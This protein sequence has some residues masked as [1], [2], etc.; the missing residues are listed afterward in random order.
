[1][2]IFRLAGPIGLFMIGSQVQAQSAC[3]RDCLADMLDSYMNA[4]IAGDPDAAPI[5]V[6]FRQTENAINVAPGAGVWQTVTGLGQVDRRYYDEVSGQAAYFGTVEEGDEEA[7][8]TVRLRVEDRELTEAEWYLARADDPGMRGA[9]PPGGPPA[10]L[11]NPE[12]LAMYPPPQRVVP[13]AQRV[14]RATLVRIG[15]SYFDA[16]T[17]HD[18]TVALHHEGCGRAENGSPAPGGSF[19]PPADGSEPPPVGS[20]RDC[21]AG[22]EGFDMQMVVAR[23][24]PVVDIE[25]QVVLTTGVFIRR[26]GSQTPRLVFSEWFVIDDA[27][28]R[29]VYTSMFY[30][31]ND[32][33]VPNW[34][35][36]TGNWPLPA[37][38]IPES[39]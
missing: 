1:M 31:P 30:P 24:T 22:L 12:Y 8:V 10:N 14:D 32:L 27:K 23:R 3:N 39:P 25:A 16:L 17:S 28:I 18:R 2:R 6:G 19:L 7:I 20:G 5:V 34:P 21:L 26:P 15:D 9:R 37:E 4:V 29:T 35:P 36:Y 11:H 33:A 13:P 38:I